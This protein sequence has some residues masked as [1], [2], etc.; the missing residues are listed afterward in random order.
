MSLHQ[1]Y[2]LEQCFVLPEV[3]LWRSSRFWLFF[4]FF[5]KQSSKAGEAKFLRAMNHKVSQYGRFTCTLPLV[6]YEQDSLATLFVLHAFIGK[7]NLTLLTRQ[8]GGSEREKLTEFISIVACISE[9]E[10]ITW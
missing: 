7:L 9:F 5:L 2:V 6:E 1:V 8:K 10:G 4:V 3:T